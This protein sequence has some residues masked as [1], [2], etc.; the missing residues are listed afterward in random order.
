[1]EDLRKGTGTEGSDK[2]R[3]I[4]DVEIR[5]VTPMERLESF[6]DQ[7]V[8]PYH[9]KV[10]NAVVRVRFTESGKTLEESI[11]SYFLGLKC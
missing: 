8:D 2:L 11:K 4:L 9:F 1:M 10:G 7:I 6:L 3:D 5:G